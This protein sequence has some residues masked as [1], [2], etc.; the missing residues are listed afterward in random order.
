M[1]LVERKQRMAELR[2]KVL[3]GARFLDKKKPNWHKKVDLSTLNLSE[4]CHCILGQ[5]EGGSHSKWDDNGW[6]K[7]IEKYNLYNL[8]DE[9]GEYSKAVAYG[10]TLDG[11][12]LDGGDSDNWDILDELWGEAVAKRRGKKKTKVR[13]EIELPSLLKFDLEFG[14][15]ISRAQIENYVQTKLM[16]A[17]NKEAFRSID[18]AP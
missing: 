5:V 18:L 17:I 14:E 1:N 6:S 16:E 3:A 12:T 7:G 8:E 15:G 11:F 13:V 2:P 9:S 4:P 10:F